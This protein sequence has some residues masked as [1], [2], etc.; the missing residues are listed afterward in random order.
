MP[1]GFRTTCIISSILMGTSGEAVQALLSR[2]SSFLVLGPHYK[3]QFGA[4]FVEPVG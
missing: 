4:I 2:I 1:V 3:V